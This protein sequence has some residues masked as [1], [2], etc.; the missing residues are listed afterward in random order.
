MHRNPDFRSSGQQTTC[1]T[2]LS[3]EP[4]MSLTLFFSLLSVLLLIALPA[5]AQF[6][7]DNAR[8]KTFG[9][10]W[11]C[12]AG[13]RPSEGR[14]D[15]IV[16][17][18][19]AYATNRTYGRGWEC[20]HG[21]RVFDKIDC[22]AVFVPDGGFLDSTGERW[23][24]TRGF[25]KVNETCQKIVL[26][27]N[28][29]LSDT[30]RGSAWTCGRGF[31]VKDDGCAEIAVPGNAFLNSTG[32]GQAWTC[33]RGF[34]EQDGR[35]DPVVVPKNAFFND[36]T[37]GTGWKCERG[38]AVSDQTC[39][40]IELPDNAHLDRSGNRWVCNRNFQKSKG[41]CVFRE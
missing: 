30:S 20:H 40:E 12:N 14:C 6:I 33:E 38:Y 39:R 18:Q 19:N 31:E 8:A 3:T 26:P 1:R 2:F 17:P 28:A 22:R 24:C 34:F 15:E 5:F 35:C 4:Q 9:K 25:A 36:A 41:Q 16:L 11:E 27:A 10:G 37:Y 32:Y 7:P 21:F 23:R 29:Y 13:F